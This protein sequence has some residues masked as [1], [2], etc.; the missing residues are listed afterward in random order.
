MKTQQK[1]LFIIHVMVNAF[2]NQTTARLAQS[3]ARETLNS[4][5]LKV[6]GSSPTSGLSFSFA[7]SNPIHFCVRGL[8]FEVVVGW[9]SATQLTSR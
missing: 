9:I 8:S 6:V 5:H 2:I 7:I 1:K 4:G 3:V